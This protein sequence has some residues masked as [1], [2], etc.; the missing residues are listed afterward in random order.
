M[1][2]SSAVLAILLYNASQCHLKVITLQNFYHV[3]HLYHIKTFVSYDIASLK[4]NIIPHTNQLFNLKTSVS[5][6]PPP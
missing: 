2:L 5:S 6:I 1:N 3:A 4:F